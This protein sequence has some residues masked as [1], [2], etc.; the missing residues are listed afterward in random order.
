MRKDGFR[1]GLEDMQS[2]G[3]LE[4]ADTVSYREAEAAAAAAQNNK[5]VALMSRGMLGMWPDILELQIRY[6]ISIGMAGWRK[7][8]CSERP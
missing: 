1:R 4:G 8:K 3:Q 6:R 5:R 7:D 2:R